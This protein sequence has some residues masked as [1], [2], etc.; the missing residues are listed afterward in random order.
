MFTLERQ[1][2][3][4]PKRLQN[5]D[6]IATMERILQFIATKKTGG[7]YISR[8]SI[9][10]ISRVLKDVALLVNKSTIR[11]NEY[12]NGL[13]KIGEIIRTQTRGVFLKNKLLSPNV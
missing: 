7:V 5:D 1:R 12:L 11:C 3:S 9:V 10:F 4:L 6:D 2:S 8:H 13:M